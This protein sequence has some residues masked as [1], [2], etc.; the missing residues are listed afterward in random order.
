M[1]KFAIIVII[2]AAAV[3][4]AWSAVTYKN[5]FVASNEAVKAAW[6]Q[7]DNVLQRRADLIPNLA[8]AVKSFAK[9]EK[10]V[11]VGVAEA[12]AKLNGAQTIKDKIGAN[13][14]LDGALSRLMVV[15]EQYPQLR[16]SEHFRELEQELEGTENRI[17]V[18]RLRYN[19]TVQSYNL[20]VKSFP[21][22]IFAS[23]YKVEP[24]D[25]YYEATDH[26]HKAPSLALK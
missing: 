18:E 10:A 17:T 9:Q 3:S 13:Q 5:R 4:I 15:I 20:L 22:N 16:S 23:V 6:A 19:E 21:G 24:N 14:Q 12:R 26:A 8:E 2:L 11:L 7:V 1:K 25:A